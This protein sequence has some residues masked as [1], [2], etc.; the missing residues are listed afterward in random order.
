MRKGELSTLLGDGQ[1]TRQNTRDSAAKVEQAVAAGTD[2][3][4]D[5]IDRAREETVR[6]LSGEI[7]ALRADVRAV[8]GSAA[9]AVAV[10]ELRQ[11]L[12]ELRSLIQQAE[13]TEHSPTPPDETPPTAPAA[14][15]HDLTKETAPVQEPP[16]EDLPEPAQG[17][18]ARDEIAELRADLAALRGEVAQQ[19]AAA[20]EDEV[21]EEAG[22]DAGSQ[23]HRK[24]LLRAARISSATVRCHRDTWEFLIAITG[25]H[26]HFRHPHKVTDETDGLIAADLS[27]RSLIAV[28][29]SLHKAK[30]EDD[31]HGD[32][33]LA[34]AF[35][36]RI[37]EHLA[38]L[39]TNGKRVSIALDDRADGAEG[40]DPAA[41]GSE[42]S[43]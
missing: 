22:A 13:S 1:E 25:A 2:A 31:D 11:D 12:R 33:A 9:T 39:G 20:T 43:P 35:Y 10:Q 19:R 36:E 6:V 38:D 15:A 37:T 18:G 21:T 3:V 40:N 41:P 8:R 16:R 28:L 24:C 17:D 32:W 30:H 42:P 34:A 5:V 7:T 29:I 4:R 14:V 27:G 23:E 26:P